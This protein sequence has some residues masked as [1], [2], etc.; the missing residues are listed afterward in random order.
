MEKTLIQKIEDKLIEL[1]IVEL[2][3]G[4]VVAPVEE[5]PVESGATEATS[6]ETVSNLPSVI[7]V[8]FT[9]KN[10]K[11]S[12]SAIG[13]PVL[14]IDEEGKETPA[15]DG[16]YNTKDGKT[17]TVVDGKLTKE[18]DTPEEEDVE[19]APV[20]SGTTEMS[21]ETP[22]LDMAM[23]IEGNRLKDIIDMSKKGDYTIQISVDDKGTVTFGTVYANTFQNLL[24]EE[25]EKVNL[26]LEKLTEGYESI[27]EAL[28]VGETKV[29]EK[30]EVKKELTRADY[31][32]LEIQNKKSK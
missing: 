6:G 24:L 18:I 29:I 10:G 17:I 27:I 7:V 3:K 22:S 23:G 25:E 19:E 9:P 12:Y 11:I 14:S 2:A 4:D 13:A 30:P 28:K 20:E 5:A 26:K 8:E 31:L 32:K 1:G 21:I 15:D 16:D